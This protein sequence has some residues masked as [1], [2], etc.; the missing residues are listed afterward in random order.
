MSKSL[1]LMKYSEE[2]LNIIIEKR[3]DLRK[4]PEPSTNCAIIEFIG[5][6]GYFSRLPKNLTS[7]EWFNFKQQTLNHKD[8]PKFQTNY[9]NEVTDH[10]QKISKK[11][12]DHKTEKELDFLI[13]KYS[14]SERIR[15]FT[16]PLYFYSTSK[17]N[18]KSRSKIK[19]SIRGILKF[20]FK[21]KPKKKKKGST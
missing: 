8:F 14:I 10:N 12:E 13:K 18:P 3:P 1:F 20:I 19:S 5:K 21:L 4:K 7:Q 2:E 15:Q 6:Y 11:L 9:F 17:K 16:N